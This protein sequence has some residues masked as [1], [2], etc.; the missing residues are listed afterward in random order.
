MPLRQA[1]G[2]VLLPVPFDKRRPEF[3]EGLMAQ[4]LSKRPSTSAV[5]SLSKGSGHMDPGLLRVS[6]ERRQMLDEVVGDDAVVLVLVVVPHLI[7]PRAEF[8]K[9]RAVADV[10]DLP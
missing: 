3:V 9:D 10:Q 5:L 7:E 8:F 1:Q 2:T 4:S 6:G